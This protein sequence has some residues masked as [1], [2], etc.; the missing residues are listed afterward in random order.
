MS[1]DA[2]I[3]RSGPVIDIKCEDKVSLF[4]D[5]ALVSIALEELVDNSI[6]FNNNTV[7]KIKMFYYEQDGKQILAVAD[8]GVGIKEE[9]LNLVFEKFYQVDDFFTGQIEGWGLGLALVKMIM[10]LHNGE[11][12]VRSQ[13][14][15]GT[16]ISLRFP[17]K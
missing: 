7:K 5:K 13:Y 6:K 3:R 16:I 10:N 15:I 2:T 12:S 8:N 17:Q 14:G 4:A 9:D 1:S 11:I